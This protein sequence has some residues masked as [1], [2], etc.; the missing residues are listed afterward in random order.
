[1]NRHH[2]RNDAQ[3]SK[4]K[5]SNTNPSISSQVDVEG[6]LSAAT[7]RYA[8]NPRAPPGPGKRWYDKIPA[9]DQEQI[10]IGIEALL[11]AGCMA[12]ARRTFD[13]VVRQEMADA[14]L[15]DA[16]DGGEN[17]CG[18]DGATHSNMVKDVK[19][20]QPLN[21]SRYSLVSSTYD[22]KGMIGVGRE[23]MN[24][25]GNN[26][27]G[28]GVTTNNNNSGSM[29]PP[30]TYYPVRH[31]NPHQHH[32]PIHHNHQIFPPYGMGGGNGMIP[33][34]PPP[35]KFFNHSNTGH[36]NNMAHNVMVPPPPPPPP[37]PRIS[38]NNSCS[39]VYQL[40]CQLVPVPLV[41]RDIV[42]NGHDG[43]GGKQPSCYGLPKE[44]VKTH[45]RGHQIPLEQCLIRM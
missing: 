32:H 12:A 21:E 6:T 8:Q 18:D 41:L 16:E 45:F 24:T 30:N 7:S 40:G 38:R 35:P 44:I 37:P 17:D 5:N 23:R 28:E 13:M 34:P 36:N 26:N 25:S 20:L 11:Y 2:H 4:Q 29:P 33:P 31:Y 15:L 27:G 14:N 3:A 9:S 19:V 10:Q 39:M 1:M 43:L 22:K 42:L